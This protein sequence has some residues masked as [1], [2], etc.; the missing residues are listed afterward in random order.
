MFLLPSRLHPPGFWIATAGAAFAH[1][2]TS[3][4]SF[5]SSDFFDCTQKNDRRLFGYKYRE[6]ETHHGNLVAAVESLAPRQK[7]GWKIS[8]KT[9]KTDKLD[10]RQSNQLLLSSLQA[11]VTNS[12]SL[13]HFKACY[14]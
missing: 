3:H 13:D 7:S 6:V 14:R 8:P 9:L 4:D 10:C 1:S 12:L 5:R 11:L 2:V